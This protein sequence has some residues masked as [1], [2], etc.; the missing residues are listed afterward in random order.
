MS[1]PPN[2]V[3]AVEAQ[4]ARVQ[5]SYNRAEYL[6]KNG[7]MGLISTLAAKFFPERFDEQIL[8]NTIG[9][10]LQ[11]FKLAIAFGIMELVKE[12]AELRQMLL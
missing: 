5:G 12:N 1:V 7:A 8:Y 4:L 6:D 10:V 9:L 11:R 2:M 3:S